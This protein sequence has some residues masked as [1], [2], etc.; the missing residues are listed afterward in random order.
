[1]LSRNLRCPSANRIS[2]ASVDLPEPLKP[3]ITTI[4]SRGILTLMLF[5]LCSRAPWIEIAPF[6]CTRAIPRGSAS[7]LLA[8]SGILRGGSS[9]ARSANVSSSSV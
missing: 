3:V 9:A 7:M 4:W 6:V 8:P 5:R 2:N 1:M